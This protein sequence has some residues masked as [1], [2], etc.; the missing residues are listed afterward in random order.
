[1]QQVTQ[2]GEQVIDQHR[3]MIDKIA[4]SHNLMNSKGKIT[5]SGQ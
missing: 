5:A 1:L 3:Q 2:Q 4:E